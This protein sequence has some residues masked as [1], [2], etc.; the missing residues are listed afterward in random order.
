[1]PTSYNG[2]PASPNP[3]DFGG[4]TPLVV[5]GESFAPGVRSGDVHTVLE[6]VARQLHERVEPVVRNDWHQADD[7]GFAYRANRN[8][9]NSLSCHASATAIDYN[10]TRHPNGRRGTFTLSQVAEI[11]RILAEV[12]GCVRWG[13]AFTGVPDEMHFEII[14][15]AADVE[16]TA[17]RLRGHVN[18]PTIQRGDTGPAVELIQRFLGVVGPGDFGYGH[19]G[20]ATEA[21]VKRY[22]SMRG[23]FPDGIVGPMTWAETGL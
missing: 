3:A 22:Q 1:M 23:L 18:R 8:D 17:D 10:A 2:W 4:L 7:W 21:A 5:A 11:R 20:P 13:G 9:P 14:K 16:R 19:F 12:D 6:Y 15:N